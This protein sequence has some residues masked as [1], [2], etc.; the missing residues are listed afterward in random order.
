[1]CVWLQLGSTPLHHSVRAFARAAQGDG[2]Q[3]ILDAGACLQVHAAILPDVMVQHCHLHHTLHRTA[4]ATV[5]EHRAPVFI[6]IVVGEGV[7]MSFKDS[8]EKARD[9][10][11]QGLQA[12]FDACRDW[13]RQ[14]H[15]CMNY[16]TAGEIRERAGSGQEYIEDIGLEGT[17]AG[18]RQNAV[19]HY[20]Q[21]PKESPRA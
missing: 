16:M 17:H 21:R 2:Q 9:G 13:N 15:A 19:N 20:R 18:T 11:V 6:R 5:E 10:V 4:R 3:S 1:M 7:D 14:N 8:R 12:Y